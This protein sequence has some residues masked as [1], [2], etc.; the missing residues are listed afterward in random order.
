MACSSCKFSE[1]PIVLSTKP[2]KEDILLLALED[3]QKTVMEEKGDKFKIAA[4]SSQLCSY[5]AETYGLGY[6]L[7][8]SAAIRFSMGM[9]IVEEMDKSTMEHS[10]ECNYTPEYVIPIHKN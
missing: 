7:L 8:I 9:Q 5:F 10:K 4:L 3:L 6:A 2:E 1:C